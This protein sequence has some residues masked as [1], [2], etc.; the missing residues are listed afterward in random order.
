M[1]RKLAGFVSP[2]CM[3]YI[4]D[5]KHGRFAFDEELDGLEARRKA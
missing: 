4:W 5:E 2:Q 3:I 1:K